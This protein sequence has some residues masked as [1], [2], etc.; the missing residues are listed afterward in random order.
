MNQLVN[1]AVEYRFQLGG[2]LVFLV[3]VAWI[4][5]PSAR[6]RYEADGNIP[7]YGDKKD[8]KKRQGGR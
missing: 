8:D 1:L 4:Y 2:I 6:K 7:F 5:R 3:I